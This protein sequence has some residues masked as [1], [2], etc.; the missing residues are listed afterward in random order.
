MK[1]IVISIILIVAAIVSLIMFL[2]T[3]NEI[4]SGV[5]VTSDNMASLKLGDD[6][7]FRFNRNIATS[8]VPEGN[9]EIIGNKLLLKV[10]G[11]DDET[12]TFL[13]DKN[14]LVFDS[15][16]LADNLVEKGTTFKLQPEMKE[17]YDYRPMISYG[18]RLYF[19]TGK[20]EDGLSD[21]W[22]KISTIE[23]VCSSSEPMKKGEAYFIANDFSVGTEIYG[24]DGNEDVIYVKY[25][26]KYVEYVLQDKSK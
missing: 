9:Y 11:S 26:D 18:D 3:S 22:T 4:E 17:F 25:N 10:N 7:T 12:I 19:D 2:N 8:Y 5:Y 13:I 6:Q 15:G 16:K 24:I 1:K 14:A 21:K 23:E 20:A